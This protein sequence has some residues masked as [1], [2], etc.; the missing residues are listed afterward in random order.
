MW[1]QLF[2]GN[3]IS[4]KA[5][6]AKKRLYIKTSAKYFEDVGYENAKMS[7]LAKDLK[8]SVGTLYKI[9]DSKENLY[10][11]Y[12]LYQIS[13]FEKILSSNQTKDPLENLKLYLQY[14]YKYFI[15][16]QNSIE[17]S[18][19]H[20]PF[21]FH[22]LNMHKKHPM[23][24]IFDFLAKQLKQIV[25]DDK[26]DYKHLAILFKKLSDGYAE[27]YKMKNFDTTNVIDDTIDL[28]LNGVLSLQK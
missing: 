18:L 15:T 28:F 3:K 21:F 26:L 24:A 7:D 1:V 5:T 9:F 19:A 16:H 4:K 20:D 25:Q 27:S 14:K 22:K 8:I 13:L 17:L 10:F 12:I 6:R 11:E 23:D 2:M